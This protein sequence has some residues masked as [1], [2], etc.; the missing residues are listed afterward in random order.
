LIASVNIARTTRTF[1]C[2]SVNAQALA[3]GR[4]I[5][6]RAFPRKRSMNPLSAY[7]FVRFVAG[8]A[9]A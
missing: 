2:G 5:A 6:A 4:S 8:A 3:V 1:D 9:R 7:R